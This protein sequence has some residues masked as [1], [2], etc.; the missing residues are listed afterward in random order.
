MQDKIPQIVFRSEET[1]VIVNF[2]ESDVSFSFIKGETLTVLATE[3]KAGFYQA[4]GEFLDKGAG[5]FKA[6]G[7]E[8]LLIYGNDTTGEVRICILDAST[9][10]EKIGYDFSK[11]DVAR[12][13]RVL[14]RETA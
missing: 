9:R 3:N 11:K 13:A 7:S 8:D 5:R 1:A 2:R 4:M 6:N 12:I 14:L 10:K